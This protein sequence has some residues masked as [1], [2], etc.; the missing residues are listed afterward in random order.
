MR[1]STFH[2]E[3]QHKDINSKIIVGL[4]RISEA[5]RVLLWEHAK[6]NAD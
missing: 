4:E 2:L 5:F 1:K 6:R 3:H